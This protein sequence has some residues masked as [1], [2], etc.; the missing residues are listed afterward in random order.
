MC[1]RDSELVSAVC[2]CKKKHSKFA[3]KGLNS[4][5][6]L[7]NKS[8]HVVG[9]TE[10]DCEMYQIVTTCEKQIC[11]HSF[12]RW[13]NNTVCFQELMV[14]PRE[15]NVFFTAKIHA[16][17]YSQNFLLRFDKN[18]TVKLTACEARTR[19]RHLPPTFFYYHC[20]VGGHVFQ[21]PPGL[22]AT[23]WVLKMTKNKVLP[24]NKYPHWE[25][26]LSSLLVHWP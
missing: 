3:F 18:A 8:F 17:N 6:Q 22:I 26:R 9:G 21:S 13:N 1:I 20:C 7:Q 4:S 16:T 14:P 11:D 24:N 5:T 25:I 15:Y 10:T 19:V 23:L 2:S 12:C